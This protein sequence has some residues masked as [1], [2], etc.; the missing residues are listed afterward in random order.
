MAASDSSQVPCKNYD[1]FIS[2]R[3]SDTR[4]GFLSH[5][6]KELHRKNIDVYVDYRLQRGDEISSALVDAIKGSMIALVIFSEDYASSKWCL[7]ELVK[8]M[9]CKEAHQQIVIPV[10]YGVDPLD[11]R[12]QK[13]TYGKETLY[14]EEKFKDKVEMWR[15]VLEKSGNLAGHDSSKFQDESKLIDAIVEDVLKELED[16]S[17]IVPN[18]LLVGSHQNF[19]IV[20]SLMEIESQEIR[21]VGIWGMGGIGKTTLARAIFEKFFSKFVS[22]GFLENIREKS[23]KVDGFNSLRDELLS[24]LLSQ[25]NLKDNNNALKRLQRKK[26]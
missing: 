26:S 24:Q 11:V 1:V 8:I 21:L 2:F 3:G 20:E 12:H 23:T 9:E 25:T 15:S 4:S 6:I 17:P 5:L 14:D 16:N 18:S 10:F 7:E 19:M 22:Y 13:G